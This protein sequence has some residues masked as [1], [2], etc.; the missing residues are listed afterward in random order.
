MVIKAVRGSNPCIPGS[1]AGFCET[2]TAAKLENP[3]RVAFT[4]IK[5]ERINPIPVWSAFVVL[6]E[7]CAGQPR[8]NSTIGCNGLQMHWHP[9]CLSWPF[10]INDV[11]IR[12]PCLV[13]ITQNG[14]G[15]F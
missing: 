3:V 15:Q 10:E 12:H 5:T 11:Q 9:I 2:R 6:F 4:R 8:S 13:E 7:L 14:A 1:Q